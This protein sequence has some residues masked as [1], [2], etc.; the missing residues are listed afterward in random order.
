MP[1]NSWTGSEKITEDMME[2]PTDAEVQ[3]HPQWSRQVSSQVRS[4]QVQQ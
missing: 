1:Q 2:R 3:P 4:R